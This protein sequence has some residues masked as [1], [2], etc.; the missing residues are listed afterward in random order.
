[1]SRLPRLAV[2]DVNGDAK[3]DAIV[4]ANQIA[5]LLGTMGAKT[6]TSIAIAASSDPASAVQ[7]VTLSA[8][9]SVSGARAGT[10]RVT[11]TMGTVTLG[12]ASL[13]SGVARLQIAP[14]VPVPLP[15]DGALAAALLGLGSWTSRRRTLVRSA[16]GRARPRDLVAR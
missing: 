6:P 3:P 13:I 14:P 8:T 11:F 7:S 2:G 10:G 4:N 16:R 9:V 1:M 15:F 5:T 12:S